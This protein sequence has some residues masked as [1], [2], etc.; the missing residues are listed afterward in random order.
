MPLLGPS[1]EDLFNLCDRKL[2]MKTTLMIFYQ[3]LERAEYIHS[4]DLIHCDFKPDN[5]M[6]GLGDNSNMVHL[7]DFGLS[8][9]VI[10]KSDGKHIKM[11]T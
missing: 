6:F 1:L 11:E 2:T 10:N 8:S 7:I 5:L 3:L 9:S 4:L